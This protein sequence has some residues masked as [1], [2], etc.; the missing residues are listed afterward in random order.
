MKLAFCK[1]HYKEIQGGEGLLANLQVITRQALQVDRRVVTVM[2]TS[3][4]IVA[5]RCDKWFLENSCRCTDIA[6][7]TSITELLVLR[8][9]Q[10]CGQG[11]AGEIAV[12]MLWGVV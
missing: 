8:Q 9:P 5:D 11:L 1:L 7:F 3:Q 4:S 10:S 2:P 6:S 12:C